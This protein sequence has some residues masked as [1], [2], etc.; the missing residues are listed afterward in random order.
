MD[1]A[2]YAQKFALRGMHS[3]DRIAFRC[4]SEILAPWIRG[5]EVLDVGCGAGRSTRFL[6]ELGAAVIGVDHNP[7]MIARAKAVDPQ[8]AQYRVIHADQPL[9][10]QDGAYDLIFSSW[11]LLEIG[12]RQTMLR[13]L[14]DCRRVLGVD[15]RAVIIVN[16]E[17]FYVGQWLSMAVNFPENSLPLRSGQRVKTRLLPEGVE[18][19]DFYWS[20]A[21]YRAF[22]EETGFCVQAVHEPL[23]REGE[24]LPW[25]DEAHTAPFAVYELRT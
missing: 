12:D 9:P 14:R 17:A 1:D 13:L 6:A 8:A 24:G 15:G 20:E 10:G 18:L 2:E 4:A 21:D 3:S 16:T 7:E 22:F 11:M 23:G 5:K 25:R 19:S